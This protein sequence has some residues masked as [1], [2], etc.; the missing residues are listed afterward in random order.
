M[1]NLPAPLSSFVGRDAEIAQVT[2]LL[3]STQLLTL[4]GPG[5][6]GKTRLAL[7]V[8]NELAVDFPDGIIFVSLAPVNDPGLVTATIAAAL[9]VTE[10]PGIP[11]LQGLIAGLLDRQT[12]LLLDNF[13]HVIEA[14]PVI[15]GLLPSCHHLRIMVTSRVPL[16]LTGEQEFPVPPLTIPTTRTTTAVERAMEYEAMALFVQRARAV[17]PTF[18][19]TAANAPAIIEICQQLDGMALAIELAAARMKALTPEGAL[20]RLNRPL[21]LL[22][23]GP[24][25]QP[26]RQQTMR[27]AI[28]WSY[29]LLEPAEQRLFRQLSTFSGGWTLE[30]ARAVCASGDT[31][32]DELL[33]QLLGLVDKSLIV[34]RSPATAEHEDLP[35]FG[36]LKTIREFGQE[37]LTLH[38]VAH[39]TSQRHAAYLLA[40]FERS[41]SEW[42]STRQMA[43]LARG[44]A[45]LDNVRAALGWATRHDAEMALRMNTAFVAYWLERAHFTEG[46]RWFELGLASDA[47]VSN[48]VRA[49]A[50]TYTGFFATSQGDYAV[51]QELCEEA[52]AISERIGNRLGQAEGLYCLGRITMFADD[53]EQA[54]Q[55]LSSALTLAREIGPIIWLPSLL[56]NLAAVA[57]ERN[58]VAAADAY[59]NEALDI[60]REQQDP[61]GMANSLSDIARVSLARSDSDGAREQL[62]ESLT[63]QRD[64]RDPRYAAQTFEYCAWLAAISHQ[65]E[66]T[67]RLLGA[68]EA[69]R[70]SIGVPVPPLIRRDYD[71]YVPLARARIDAAAWDRAWGEG[72]SSTLDESIVFAMEFP[73]EPEPIAEPPVTPASDAVGG[74]SR[75]EIEVLRLLVDGRSNQDI[76]GALFISPH[77]AARH[78][79]NIMNKLGVESR[80]AAATWALRHGLDLGGQA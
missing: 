58:D 71:T 6:V 3:A 31:S 51:A 68:A 77:T 26:A 47:E 23:G 34:P 9:G 72:H 55:L 12:L 52:L 56:G 76:A 64:I 37:Q 63:L 48:T 43:W 16:H 61:G 46:R 1:A 38:D 14:T 49:T 8:A 20:A 44:D 62:L 78:V 36:M 28:A 10:Q 57:T 69:M 50:L 19:L 17:N 33:D 18:A 53:H 60:S 70:E 80:T 2:G 35:R 54:Y 5:G 22:T 30:A 41:M 7:A 75:R 59:V 11:L 40:Y 13:E 24:S 65:P 25:D 4:T 79:A 73:R 42:N 27:A 67:A 45:E 74:L 39:D 29:D 21:S 32:E 15:A 66:R